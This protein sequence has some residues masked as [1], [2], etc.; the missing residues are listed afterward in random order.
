MPTNRTAI[1]RER[2]PSFT[3]EVLALFLE[4]ER[5]PGD[6]AFTDAS[7][8]LA[9]LLGLTTEWWMGCHVND[10]SRAPCHPPTHA[11]HGAWYAVRETRKALLRAAA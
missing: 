10:K 6:Q 8:K 4:I 1:R 7:R 11:A 2:R 9:Q 5:K 3:P